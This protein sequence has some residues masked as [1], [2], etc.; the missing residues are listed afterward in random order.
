MLVVEANPLRSE[1]PG[2][3]IL[4]GSGNVGRKLQE[5][6]LKNWQ[7]WAPMERVI[8]PWVVSGRFDLIE[9]SD[10]TVPERD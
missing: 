6:G 7:G 2:D 9:D 4:L 3:V 10:V 5:I 1:K 8:M